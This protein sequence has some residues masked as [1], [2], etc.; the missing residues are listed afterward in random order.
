[1]GDCAGGIYNY[2]VSG[3]RWVEVGEVLDGDCGITSAKLGW[4][5]GI[6]LG[7]MGMMGTYGTLGDDGNKRKNH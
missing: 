5:L 2:M 4:W 6:S 3:W 7:T 1:M